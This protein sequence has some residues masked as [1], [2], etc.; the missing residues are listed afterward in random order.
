MSLVWENFVLQSMV[1]LNIHDENKD[2]GSQSYKHGLHMLHESVH[3][4]LKNNISSL[5]KAPL[6]NF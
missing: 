6:F 3:I 2:V 1:L 4:I 5:K